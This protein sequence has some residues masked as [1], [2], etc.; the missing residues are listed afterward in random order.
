MCLETK[1][2]ILGQT[3]EPLLE[4]CCVP[5]CN[6]QISYLFLMVNSNFLT[7]LGL[8]KVTYISRV[9]GQSSRLVGQRAKAISREA[10]KRVLD[11]RSWTTLAHPHPTTGSA[12]GGR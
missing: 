7:H 5:F 1:I 9:R 3:R 4:V 10:W 8:L 12:I 2:Q 6:L 11:R